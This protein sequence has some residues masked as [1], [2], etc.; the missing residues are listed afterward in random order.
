MRRYLP[1]LLI[2]SGLLALGL[3]LG[4]RS[5]PTLVY[6]QP[7]RPTI[8]PT[9]TPVTSTPLVPTPKPKHKS[10]DATP[11]PPG[12]ITGTVIDLTSGAPAPGIAVM[13]GDVR[14]VSDANGN[15]DRNGLPPGSYTVTLAL[16]EGQGT[17]AQAPIT[18]E[19]AAGATVVQHLA[20]RSPLA[21]TVVPSAT[22]AVVLTKL[23]RTGGSDGGIG[24][25]LL[26]AA[27][28]LAGGALTRW[29][30]HAAPYRDT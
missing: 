13:V 5:A 28:A 8:V 3:V 7:P 24:A 20:F 12:R 30:R 16:A 18:V 14:V 4:S 17:P 6:A 19:L 26:L 27:L 29:R 1:S 2:S 9:A 25:A 21:A 11:V 15:Y 10:K 22:P 23:P